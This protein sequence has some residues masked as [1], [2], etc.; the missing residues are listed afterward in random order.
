MDNSISRRSTESNFASPEFKHGFPDLLLIYDSNSDNIEILSSNGN[1]F[2]DPNG[3]SFKQLTS[4]L[5]LMVQIN[6]SEIFHNKWTKCL[7]LQ[8]EEE[9][10]F[11]S[12]FDFKEIKQVAFVITCKRVQSTKQENPARLVF[13]FSRHQIREGNNIELADIHSEIQKL[14]RDQHEF[15]QIA[16]HDLLAPLRKVSSFADLLMSKLNAE[17]NT[18]IGKYIDKMD[19]SISQMRDII[20]RLTTLSEVSIANNEFKRCELTEIVKKALSKLTNLINLKNADIRLTYLPNITGIPD[21]LQE[22]FHNLIENALIYSLEDR[23]VNI[24]IQVVDFDKKKYMIDNPGNK[25]FQQIVIEDNGI[26]M[27]KEIQDKIFQPF[28]R[29]HGKSAYPGYG[30]GLAICKRIVENHNGYIFAESD[31]KGS[32]FILIL[33][34]TQQ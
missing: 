30:L 17:T 6:E 2:P 21:Q 23:G 1:F 26:G 19:G 34:S 7:S 33:P 13:M 15:I 25:L 12:K 16:S 14:R 9:Y 4:Y 31:K 10:S 22:L 24:D 32:R 28:V 5:G 27:N 8:V 20:T 3:F 11:C 29:G 18:D